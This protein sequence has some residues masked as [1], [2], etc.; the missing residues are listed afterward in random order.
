MVLEYSTKS[1]DEYIKEGLQLARM[2]LAYSNDQLMNKV[3]KA[4]SMI[5]EYSTALADE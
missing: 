5:L 1:D 2:I 3:K 4:T